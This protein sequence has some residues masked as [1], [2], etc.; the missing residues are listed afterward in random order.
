MIYLAPGTRV[1]YV[2]SAA[3]RLYN[4]RYQFSGTSSSIPVP[5][6]A[7]T[8]TTVPGKVVY[9]VDAKCNIGLQQ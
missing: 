6:S 1:Q 4:T 2:D 5:V 3:P 8:D 7:S 9:S